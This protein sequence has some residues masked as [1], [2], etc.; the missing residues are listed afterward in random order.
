MLNISNIDAK[1][2]I[3]LSRWYAEVLVPTVNV[4]GDKQYILELNLSS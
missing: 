4:L 1:N 3:F 2:W